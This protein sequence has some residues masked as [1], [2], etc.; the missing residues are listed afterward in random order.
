MASFS[1]QIDALPSYSGPASCTNPPQRRLLQLTAGRLCIHLL[2]LPNKTPHT[3][4]LTQPMYFLTV[5]EAASPRCSC[6]QG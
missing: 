1:D 2:G 6:R 3:G 4:W 5:L